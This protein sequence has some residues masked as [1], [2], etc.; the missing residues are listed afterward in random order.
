M[1]TTRDN[2][3]R[4]VVCGQSTNNCCVWH[5]YFGELLFSQ[6]VIVVAVL[7]WLVSPPLPVSFSLPCREQV[8]SRWK[9]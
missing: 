9:R 8:R 4:P 6:D 1:Y 7:D 5:V 3:V 2:P